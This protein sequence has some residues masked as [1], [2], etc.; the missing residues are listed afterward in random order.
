MVK[1]GLLIQNGF[2]SEGRR[3]KS[4]LPGSEC[5]WLSQ[6]CSEKSRGQGDPPCKM[7]YDDR[8]VA[9][10]VPCASMKDAGGMSKRRA[11]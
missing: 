11:G 8:Q 7:T 5:C 1:M 10:D 9:S 2:G 4:S 3:Y 6:V